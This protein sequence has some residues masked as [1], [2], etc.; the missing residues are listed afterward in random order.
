MKKQILAKYIIIVM[1]IFLLVSCTGISDDEAVA[2]I[3]EYKNTL[4]GL[5]NEV[6]TKYT[7]SPT[8]EDWQTFSKD[9][10]PRLTGAKPE[11]LLENKVEKFSNEIN[12]LDAA[13]SKMMYL[14][15]EYDKAMGG[16]ELR[17]ERVNEFKE[18]IEE[19]FENVNI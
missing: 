3:G 15:N 17:Q 8:G 5:Y 13:S 2:L 12:A 4:E 1:S 10:M 11:K 18:M 6:N 9:W 19:I 7:E 14:W 16:K